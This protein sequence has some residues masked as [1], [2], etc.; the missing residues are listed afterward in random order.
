MWIGKDSRGWGLGTRLMVSRSRR[1]TIYKQWPGR[2]QKLLL[3]KEKPEILAGIKFGIWVPN[4]HRKGIG[5]FKF[6]SL[7]QDR[8]T[9]NIYA[10][11]KFWR[12]LIWRLLRQSA[13]LPNLIPCQ[14]FWLYGMVILDYKQVPIVVAGH[15]D[16]QNVQ[17]NH[18]PSLTNG[19][20]R[21]L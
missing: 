17:S 2:R 6:G 15:R 9:Y 19:H 3:D 16:F 12:I 8:H 20:R 18:L 7:V 13:N 11:K 1:I 10:S 21:I 4:C 14:I 5:G